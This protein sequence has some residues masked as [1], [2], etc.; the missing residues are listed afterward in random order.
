MKIKKERSINLFA[1]RALEEIKDE[2]K[3]LYLHNEIPWV[4]GYSGGKDS[5]AVVQLVYQSLSEIPEKQ[6]SKVVYVL[7]SDTKVET[8]SIVNHIY[9]SLKLIA[10]AAKMD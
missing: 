6:R 2:I 5:T 10:E 4:I 8:P 1:G 7:T 9:I 3:S